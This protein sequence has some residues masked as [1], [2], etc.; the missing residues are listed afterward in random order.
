M[1][2]VLNSNNTHLIF[3]K[4]YFQKGGDLANRITKKKNLNSKLDSNL[5]FKW[6]C[7]LIRGIDY[8]HRNDIMHRNINPT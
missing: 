4:Y 8:L 6:T 5:I 2:Y 1:K 7:E 3:I